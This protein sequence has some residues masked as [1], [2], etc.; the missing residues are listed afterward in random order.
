MGVPK[1]IR[2][3]PKLETK[4]RQYLKKNKIKFS[5]LVNMAVDKFISEPQTIT[6]VPAETKNFMETVDEVYEEHKHAMDKLK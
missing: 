3:E 6:L 4:V 2:F 1:T 5:Q